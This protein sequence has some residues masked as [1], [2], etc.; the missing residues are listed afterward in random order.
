MYPKIWLQVGALNKSNYFIYK[1]DLNT[2]EYY[3]S[4]EY[5]AKLI[6]KLL[7]IYLFSGIGVVL[8]R[9]ETCLNTL[10]DLIQLGLE[11]LIVL[12]IIPDKVIDP[13]ISYLLHLVITENMNTMW[14]PEK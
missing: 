14:W 1:Y 12:V 10:Y 7:L 4:F 13:I 6:N 2:T 9:T 11:T 8:G 3:V 5:L